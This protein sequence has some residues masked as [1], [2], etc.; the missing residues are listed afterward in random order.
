MMAATSVVV[1]LALAP[2][3]R[4]TATVAPS[5]HVPSRSLGRT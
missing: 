3:L 4:P 1:T 2:G 5:L